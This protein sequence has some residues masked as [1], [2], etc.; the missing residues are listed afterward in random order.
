MHLILS[1]LISG[2]VTSETT[3]DMALAVSPV[4]GPPVQCFAENGIDVSVSF[5]LLDKR[6]IKEF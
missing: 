2:V 4:A 5:S 6:A 1:L 3:T